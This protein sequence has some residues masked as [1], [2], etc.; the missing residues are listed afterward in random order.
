MISKEDFEQFA[1]QMVVTFP[2]MPKI[3]RE[4]WINRIDRVRASSLSLALKSEKELTLNEF[5]NLMVS[6]R[7]E[8]EG[9]I[10]VRITDIRNIRE[11]L[12]CEP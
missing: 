6:S 12:R 10:V 11:T 2:F 4:E 3:V 7:F 5:M 9:Q 1:H 8:S